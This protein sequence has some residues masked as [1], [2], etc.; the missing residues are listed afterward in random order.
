MDLTN[1]SV[2]EDDFSHIQYF[3]NSE[4]YLECADWA[5]EKRNNTAIQYCNNFIFIGGC[6]ALMSIPIVWCGILGNLTLGLA[7]AK[8]IKGIGNHEIFVVAFAIVETLA[9]IFIVLFDFL[10]KGVPWLGFTGVYVLYKSTLSCKLFSFAGIFLDSLSV[11]L[12]LGESFHRF[13][14]LKFKGG[15]EIQREFVI[16]GVLVII[17]FSFIQSAP[18]TVIFSLWLIDGRYDCE[19]DCQFPWPIVQWTGIH[20]GLFCNGLFQTLIIFFLNSFSWY[21]WYVLY[22]TIHTI[23]TATNEYR[24]SS[25]ILDEICNSLTVSLDD[26]FCTLVHTTVGAAILNIKAIF[27]LKIFYEFFSVYED[28]TTVEGVVYMYYLRTL[29][30][31]FSTLFYLFESYHF[32]LYFFCNSNFRQLIKTKIMMFNPESER[33]SNVIDQFM[34]GDSV[35]KTAKMEDLKMH[36]LVLYERIRNFDGKKPMRRRGTTHSK[37]TANEQRKTLLFRRRRDE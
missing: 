30:Q 11:N 13:L 9:L 8:Y 16:F 1:H 22:H 14:I 34:M 3:Y 37:S 10:S 28:N 33:L 24:L 29:G 27:S 19:I 7:F 35:K 15:I 12:L 20:F 23:Q 32:W 18:L 21:Y 17:I 4:M 26:A 2:S 6:F 5:L 25:K 36:N 31:I